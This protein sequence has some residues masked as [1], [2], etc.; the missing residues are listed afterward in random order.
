MHYFLDRCAANKVFSGAY[1]VCF[2][3]LDIQQRRA[4]RLVDSEIIVA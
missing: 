3:G 4:F 1:F 2:S